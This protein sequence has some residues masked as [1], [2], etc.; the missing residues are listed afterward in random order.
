MVS[1]PALPAPAAIAARTAGFPPTSEARTQSSCLRFTVLLLSACLFL[2]RFGIPLGSHSISVVGPVGLGLAAYGVARG[3]LALHRRRLAIYLLV[4]ALVTLGAAWEAVHPNHFN[5][6]AVWSSLLQFLLLTGFAVVCFAEAADETAFF[7]AVTRV[8][9]I[10]AAAG[11]IQ[12][13]VQFVGVKIFAFSDFLPERFLYEAGY[14]LKIPVGIGEVLKSNGF[15]LVEPSVF[16]QFMAVGLMIEALTARRLALLALF[17]LGLLL[18]FSGTGWIVLVTFG[19]TAFVGLGRRGAV[20]G[21]GALLILA[22]AFGVMM[23]LA[24]DFAAALSDRLAE[25]QTPGT[26]AHLR[27]I[28]PFWLLQDVLAR[29][30]S[31]LLMGIGAGASERL[32]MP[33]E[34]DVNTPVKI[35]LEYGVPVL[36]AYVALFVVAARTKT[37]GALV[38]P[39]LVLFFFTGGYQQF[40]PVLFPVLL[41]LVVARLRP[42]GLPAPDAVFVTQG[43]VSMPI[44]QA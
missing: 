32:T 35:V 31:A 27:F 29:E 14:N 30:P 11:I 4:L 42:P 2:Q 33:Y 26:S 19:L 7:H 37:Q 22:F 17:A 15:F 25:F 3:T 12:F 13:A 36:L 21:L 9:A 34:Y 24:P 8:L 23:V 16:S 28:T 6:P 41:L 5:E 10:I 39:V 40:P 18:S 38:A 20:I 44:G 43:A 1:S